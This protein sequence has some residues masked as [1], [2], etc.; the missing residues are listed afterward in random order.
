MKPDS[1]YR[2]IG[3]EDAAPLIT[4]MRFVGDYWDILARAMNTDHGSVVR[5]R[6]IKN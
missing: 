5:V 1:S 3:F 2:A 6:C 4:Y